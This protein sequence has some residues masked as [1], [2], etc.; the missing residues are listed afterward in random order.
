MSQSSKQPMSGLRSVKRDFS[1]NTLQPAASQGPASSDTD[2]IPWEPT[3]PKKLTGLEQRLKDIQDALNSQISSSEDTL[4]QTQS[5]SQK[6]PSSSQNPPAKRRQL[7]STWDVK[8]VK[9]AHTSRPTYPSASSSRPSGATSRSGA[10]ETLVVPA[11]TKNSATSKPA[12]VFLSQE[13]THILRLVEAGKSLFYTG[14]AGKPSLTFMSLGSFGFAI[15]VA[16]TMLHPHHT[17]REYGTVYGPLTPSCYPFAS[18]EQLSTIWCGL[19]H[20]CCMLVARGFRRV[21]SMQHG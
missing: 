21:T 3:P 13:Q 6:R 1:S 7:P 5:Q 10:N 9:P 12:A 19:C 8:D 14:S 15:G 18:N 11:A 17:H 20:R 16:H 2:S 4:S